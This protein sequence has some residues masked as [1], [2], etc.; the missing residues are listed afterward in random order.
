[1]KDRSDWFLNEMV[2]RRTVRHFST[3]PVPIEVIKNCLQVACTAPSGANRQPWKF[4]VI[5]D[6]NLKKEIR[7]HTVC[8]EFL[9]FNNNFSH[10]VP[11]YEEQLKLL[12]EHNQILMP[13]IE[14]HNGEIIKHTGDGYFAYFLSEKDAIVSAVEFQTKIKHR[15]E[16]AQNKHQFQVRVGIHKGEAVKKNN[17]LFGHVPFYEFGRIFCGDH[18]EE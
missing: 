7:K 10:L 13:S 15:N 6:E 1:M 12:E 18:C 11:V 8:L 5:E 3:T 2:K 9:R 16:I 17:D 14:N 4:V